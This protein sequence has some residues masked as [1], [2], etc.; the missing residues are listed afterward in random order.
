MLTPTAIPAEP[1]AT[2]ANVP[3]GPASE[4]DSLAARM[5]VPVALIGALILAGFVAAKVKGR[6]VASEDAGAAMASGTEIGRP[7][8]GPTGPPQAVPPAE[9]PTGSPP[10]AQSRDTTATSDAAADPWANA[11]T[12]AVHVEHI[13]E[14]DD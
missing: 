1:S 2:P 7:H 5:V 14:V 13:D 10:A 6:P 9:A 3:A 4:L 11:R 12:I 8:P